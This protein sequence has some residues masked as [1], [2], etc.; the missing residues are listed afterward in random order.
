MST[1]H[2]YCKKSLGQ[3]TIALPLLEEKNTKVEA[4]RA[5]L[6]K[7]KENPGDSFFIMTEVRWLRG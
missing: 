6:T 3:R 5:F 7:Q 1:W 2:V 4:G